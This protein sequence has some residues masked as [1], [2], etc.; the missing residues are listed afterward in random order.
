MANTIKGL[1]PS[2]KAPSVLKDEI[3]SLIKAEAPAPDLSPYATK[4]ELAEVKP[5]A[6][7]IAKAQGVWL[8]RSDTQPEPTMYGVPVIWVDTANPDEY[9]PSAPVF[10]SSTR[11][12][13]IPADRG[14]TYWVDGTEVKA[15]THTAPEPYPKT[16]TITAKAKP[17]FTFAVGALTSWQYTFEAVPIPYEDAVLPMSS[18]WRLDDAP[19]TKAPRDR[20]TAPLARYN[21]LNTNT[22]TFG[23]PGIGVGATSAKITGIN[24]NWLHFS[25]AQVTAFTATAVMKWV[26]GGDMNLKLMSTQNSSFAQLNIG[27]QGDGRTIFQPSFS[28]GGASAITEITKLATVPQPADG[29]ILHIAYTWDG[30]TLTGYV[31]GVA[32]VSG[33]WAGSQVA[34]ELLKGWET[35]GSSTGWYLAGVGITLGEAKSAQWVA[36]ASKAVKR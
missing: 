34:S 19:G 10:T 2:G 18:Y 33:K 3:I 31:D 30:A 35:S 28:G 13:T 27:S 14:A 29:Q 21:D 12:Y 24:Q 17:G 11:T 1:L 8:V 22:I 15:G 20:G 36:E 5:T 23:S 4:E 25:P 26:N 6:E 32:A 9:R 7:A 16:I